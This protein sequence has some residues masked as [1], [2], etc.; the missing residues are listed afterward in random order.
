[1]GT[2]GVVIAVI[3]VSLSC[4]LSCV[5][6]LLLIASL[7]R[8]KVVGET[9]VLFYATLPEASSYLPWMPFTAT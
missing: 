3:D 4:F 7:S 2:Q 6:S 1:M 8:G 9:H 5:H